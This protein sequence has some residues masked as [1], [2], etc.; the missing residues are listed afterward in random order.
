M[1]WSHPSSNPHA[2]KATEAP[3]QPKDHGWEKVVKAK[4]QYQCLIGLRDRMDAAVAEIAK[5]K[6][7]RTFVHE[8]MGLFKGHPMTL[9][10]MITEYPYEIQK[11]FFAMSSD[12]KPN[13]ESWQNFQGASKH[14]KKLAIAVRLL[15][16][17]LGI[18]EGIPQE[19]VT[20]ASLAKVPL[21][22][23]RVTAISVTQR[24]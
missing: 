2:R 5:N 8:A 23:R 22:H 16:Q 6:F 18:N 4:N 7:F 21:I 9:A 20:E 1:P 24:C 14:Q 15:T 13:T 17:R 3:P 19:I 10:Q 12:P 11:A